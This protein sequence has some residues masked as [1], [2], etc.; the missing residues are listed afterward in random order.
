[1]KFLFD[2]LP[3][4]FFFATYKF[5][6]RMPDQGAAFATHW[7]GA[8]VQGGVVGATEAPA[9]LA[10]VVVL[11]ATLV[12]VAWMKAAGRKVDMALWISLVMIVIFGGLTVWFHN[13]MF[14]M[15]KPTIYFW[16]FG[17]VFWASKALFERNLFRSML[18]AAEVELPE[19]VWQRLNISWIVLCLLIG[20]LNLVM[21]YFL[22]DYWVA[23]HTFGTTGLMLAFFVGMVVYLGKHL[24]PHQPADEPAP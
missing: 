20:A 7:L 24:E 14:I 17:L 2:V 11:A 9:L 16:G 13:Q 4:V 10:T 5:A 18:T 3:L 22:R 12:Q 23:F 21:V 6:G 8:I 1:M 19:P 15:W